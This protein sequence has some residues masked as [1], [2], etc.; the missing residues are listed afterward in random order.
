M[1]C[2]T[3][4]P[5]PLNASW[6]NPPEHPDKIPFSSRVRT[7]PARELLLAYLYEFKVWRQVEIF[8]RS[9][10]SQREMNA[11]V[12]SDKVKSCTFEH[13][14][15]EGYGCET[16][17]LMLREWLRLRVS[18]NRV[19]RKRFGHNREQ[20]TKEWRRLRNKELYGVNSP[21]II[22]VIRSRRTW[23]AKYVACRE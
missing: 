14:C 19:L 3:S 4:P 7:Y 1:S 10:G 13:F 12:D 6:S 21:N 15:Y 22:R 2:L 8:P 11:N 23:W 5:S 9:R 16:C 20:V 18:E 17:S